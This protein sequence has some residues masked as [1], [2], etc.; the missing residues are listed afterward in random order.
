MESNKRDL[1]I[2]LY[3]CAVGI[4]VVLILIVGLFK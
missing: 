1:S 2:P 3:F 4:V